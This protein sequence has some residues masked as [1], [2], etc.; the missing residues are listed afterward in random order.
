MKRRLL[1]LLVLKRIWVVVVVLVSF[2]YIYIYNVYNGLLLLLFIIC[3]NVEDY[4][5]EFT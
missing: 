1:R 4:R 2:I 5:E 3:N